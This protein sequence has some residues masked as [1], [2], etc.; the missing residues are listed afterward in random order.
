MKSL[1]LTALLATSP[2]PLSAAVVHSGPQDLSV[3]WN[4]LDGLYINMN[5]GEIAHTW[6]DDFYDAPWINI[7]LGGNGIFN[8]DVLRPIAT[9]AGTYDPELPTDYYLN[10][11]PGTVV[12]ASSAFVVEGWGSTLH[13]GNSGDPGKF[14]VNESGFLGFEFQN[15]AGGDIHYG[16]LH[17]TPSND[18]NGTIV[19]WAYNDTA[20][21]AIQVGVVPVPEPSTSAVLL[22]TLG[23]AAFRRRRA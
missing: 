17:L 10:L 9:S 20:G 19:D 18:A 21:Q 23:I 16:W 7:T 15:Q 4:D 8:S 13:M 12:D 22:G 3:T 1:L 2:V 5:T 6:P 11:A 14:V